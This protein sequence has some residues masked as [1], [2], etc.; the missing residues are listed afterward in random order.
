MKIIIDEREHQLYEKCYSILH[1]QVKASYIQLSKEVL[2]IGDII[3]KTDENKDVLIIERK[4]LS[5]LLSSIKDGRYEEQSFRLLHS[6]GFPPHSVI[7]L[8]EG[9]FSQMRNPIEKKI[10]YSA[11]TSLQFFKGFSVHRTYS[12]QET[13]EWLFHMG[14]KIER[15]FL[16][17]KI[18]YYL[19]SSYL[20][21][22]HSSCSQCS[23]ILSN[24][25]SETKQD[26]K[27]EKKE[28]NN[29]KNEII[30]QITEADYCNVVKKVKKENVTPDN[31]GEI[32]LCQIPGISS[33]TAITIMKK[34]SGFYNFMEELQKNPNCIDEI[35]MECNGKIR[36]ISK[37]SLE[38]IKKYLLHK[39]L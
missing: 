10:V 26:E 31:I 11:M 25:N 23:S 34:F 38:N 12:V 16:K 4:S 35:T 20:S 5:D 3:L 33:V 39:K 22:S 29:N 2:P 1:S 28:E 13:A 24:E 32:I 21:S 6:S 18:P 17:G 36:K 30:N 9:M 7:Y 27:E 37:S 8:L 14:D 19:S 15:E